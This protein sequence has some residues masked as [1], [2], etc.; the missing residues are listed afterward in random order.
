MDWKSLGFIVLFG[1][2]WY[3][4]VARILPRFGVGT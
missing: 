2:A 1:V 4:L 3:F